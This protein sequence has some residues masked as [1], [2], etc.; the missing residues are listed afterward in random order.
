VQL[1]ILSEPTY[2]LTVPGGVSS[3]Q[4]LAWGGSG[5]T[6]PGANGGN[7]AAVSATL[8]VTTGQVLDFTPGCAGAGGAGEIPLGRP[9]FDGGN[10]DSNANP[11]YEGP[12]TL[13]W[14]P[15]S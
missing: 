13:E 14:A 9:K 10:P 6:I 12:F 2:Q 5:Q 15:Q 3:V 7:G 8:P 4:V 11:P 1:P